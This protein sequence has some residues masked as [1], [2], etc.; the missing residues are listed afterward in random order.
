M[1]PFKFLMGWILLFPVCASAQGQA[2][3]YRYAVVALEFSDQDGQFD[4]Q[5][6]A[7][8]YI[9][10][11]RPRDLTDDFR[12]STGPELYCILGHDSSARR[13]T[14]RIR[15]PLGTPYEYGDED[16]LRHVMIPESTGSLR[17]FLPWTPGQRQLEIMDIN[18]HRRGQRHVILT[19][20]F[21]EPNPS[22]GQ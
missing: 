6:S 9:E 21:P 10:S 8:V 5:A 11:K 2:P 1:S 15:D 22:G 4:V 16:G 13:D 18:V 20:D 17:L 12:D 14:F 3:V 7:P 19:L